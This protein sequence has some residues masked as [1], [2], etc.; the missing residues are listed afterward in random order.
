[1]ISASCWKKNSLSHSSGRLED[2][3]VESNVVTRGLDQEVSGGAGAGET[4]TSPWA[5]D[6][7]HILTRRLSVL[8]L[9][10]E[11]FYEVEL[12]SN[13]LNFGWREFQDG[14]SLG[15]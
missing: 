11:N 7:L 14:I 3:I 4:N 1:M 13:R 15:L 8:C 6:H 5:R 2:N 12:K 10:S 9:L